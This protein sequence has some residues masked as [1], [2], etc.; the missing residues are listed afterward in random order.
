M[1]DGKTTILYSDCHHSGKIKGIKIVDAK[2]PESNAHS[3][4]ELQVLGAK[5]KRLIAYDWRT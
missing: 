1:S 2:N 5:I 4:N 3:V